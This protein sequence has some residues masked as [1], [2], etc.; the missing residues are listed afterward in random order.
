[1]RETKQFELDYAFQR[2]GKK[3][4]DKYFN[5]LNFLH[6]DIYAKEGKCHTSGEVR[7]DPVCDLVK[8]KWV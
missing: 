6:G 1:M 2:K 7:T 8:T 5:A 4:K 3:Y